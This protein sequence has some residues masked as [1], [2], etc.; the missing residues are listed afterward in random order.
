MINQIIKQLYHSKPA[1][2][3]FSRVMAQKSEVQPENEVFDGT[4]DTDQAESI[5]DS[6]EA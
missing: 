2:T 4:F 6:K 1:N 5:Q 3:G